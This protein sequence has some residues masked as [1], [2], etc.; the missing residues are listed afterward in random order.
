MWTVIEKTQ[1]NMKGY[2]LYTDERKTW[3]I[4][5]HHAYWYSKSNKDKALEKA[6]LYNEK[7]L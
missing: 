4:D 7:G 6:K 3:L 2:C 5:G 1:N